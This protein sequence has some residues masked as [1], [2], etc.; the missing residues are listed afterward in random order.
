[1]ASGMCYAAIGSDTAGSI[2]EPAA[3]CGVVGFKPSYGLVS[4][5]G[6]IPLSLSLDHAGPITRKVEDAAIVLEAITQA[7]EGYRTGLNQGIE[8]FRIG[9]PRQFFFDDL[10]GEIGVA[11]ESAVSTLG[12]LGGGIRD[13]ELQVSTDRRLQGY[14]SYAYHPQFGGILPRFYQSDTPRPVQ[15]A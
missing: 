1:V 12:K 6:I 5:R 8:G 11:V 2:R 14:E 4:T 13:I 3:L 15:S 7:N 9:I 10:D